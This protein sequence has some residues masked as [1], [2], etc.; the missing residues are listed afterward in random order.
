MSCLPSMHWTYRI[1]FIRSYDRQA[2]APPIRPFANNLQLAI[3]YEV[4]YSYRTSYK[5]RQPKNQYIPYVWVGIAKRAIAAKA[6][7]V[8]VGLCQGSNLFAECYAVMLA[9]YL[10]STHELYQPNF[11]TDFSGIKVTDATKSRNM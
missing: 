1:E 3:D 5:Q 10:C 11:G 7:N 4:S 8:W 6:S 9:R 2:G